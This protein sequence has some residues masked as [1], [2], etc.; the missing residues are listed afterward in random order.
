MEYK[1]DDGVISRKIVLWWKVI[2]FFFYYRDYYFVQLRVLGF[3]S[4][5]GDIGYKF[6]LFILY[7]KVLSIGCYFVIE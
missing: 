2:F 4:G 1:I 7:M 5:G 6:Y 3:F